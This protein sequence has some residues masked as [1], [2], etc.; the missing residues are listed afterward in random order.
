MHI[1]LPLISIAAFLLDLYLR[2]L[3]LGGTEPSDQAQMLKELEKARPAVKN[4]AT[5]APLAW[6][7]GLHDNW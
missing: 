4:S 1:N 7:S 6:A 5:S 2:S 3:M